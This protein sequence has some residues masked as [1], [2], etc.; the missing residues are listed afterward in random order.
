VLLIVNMVQKIEWIWIV[1]FCRINDWMDG[2]ARVLKI[3]SRR[4]QTVHQDGAE[5]PAPWRGQSAP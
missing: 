4:S 3:A 2:A 1:I 5:C